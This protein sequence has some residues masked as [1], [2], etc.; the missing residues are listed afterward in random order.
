[1][2]ALIRNMRVQG[3]IARL[4]NGTSVAVTA[5]GKGDIVRMSEGETVP[6]DGDVVSHASSTLLCDESA[7]TGEHAVV[8]KRV[9]D[10]I[11]S[12]TVLVRGTCNVR[13]RRSAKD[14]VTGLIRQE[15]E[16]ALADRRQSPLERSCAEAAKALTPIALIVAAAAYA[17]RVWKTGVRPFTP[18]ASSS[19]RDVV[20]RRWEVILSVLMAAT[21]CPLSIGVPVAFLSA[22]SAATIGPGAAVPRAQR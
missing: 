18:L 21:P 17:G 16:A 4:T 3:K 13:L 10:M 6:A 22:R 11:Y 14:S 1:M 12:G 5:L 20:R 19:V 7:I 9:G 15:L 8:R 2:R